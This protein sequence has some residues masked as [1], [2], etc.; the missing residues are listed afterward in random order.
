MS[1]VAPI[2]LSLF[3][4][5]SRNITRFSDFPFSIFR[6]Q[7]PLDEQRAAVGGGALH[8]D[9]RPAPLPVPRTHLPRRRRGHPGPALPGGES[10]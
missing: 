9:R 1:L 6:Q 10:G 5:Q 7:Q 8:P 4:V 3:P 2:L